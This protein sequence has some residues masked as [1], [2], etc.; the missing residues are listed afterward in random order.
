MV[1]LAEI[2]DPAVDA[3]AA[4]INEPSAGSQWKQRNA[5][6]VLGR[7]GTP[8]AER[9]LLKTLRDGRLHPAIRRAAAGALGNFQSA[10]VREALLSTYRDESLE[11]HLR[12]NALYALRRFPSGNLVEIL[13]DAMKDREPAIHYRAGEALAEM[14]TPA[15]VA[16]LV[17]GLKLH[18]ACLFD[19]AVREALA[20][21][22]TR[23]TIDVLIAA[24]KNEKWTVRSSAAKALERI[25]KPAA[26][27]LAGY[28]DNADPRIRWN[29][30][31]L[32][33][34]IQAYNATETYLQALSDDDWMVRNE[35]AVALAQCDDTGVVRSLI[36]MLDNEQPH[37]RREAAWILGELRAAQ[38]ERPLISMLKKDGSAAW[39]AAV[40][41][42][43]ISAETAVGPLAE[44]LNSNNVRLRRA[45]VWAL[46]H[47]GSD[48][49]LASLNAAADDEDEDV[50]LWAR[51]ALRKTRS[52]GPTNRVATDAQ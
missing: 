13:Q 22:P 3:L 17:E 30:L 49:A 51:N 19:E 33:S 14:G 11:I 28:L 43:K 39:M 44:T 16:A 41:L 21:S 7:I 8:R 31:R 37:V 38:A 4:T 40:S 15:A 5:V 48:H 50:R 36:D 27:M 18:P 29:A 26:P 46:A 20:D 45:A 34:K 32:L 6:N 35:A 25:G 42:G 10:K 1:A 24:L 2:G 23:G 52:V 12:A 47:I 9:V